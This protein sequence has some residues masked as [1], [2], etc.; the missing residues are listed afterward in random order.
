M[1]GVQRYTQG[2]QDPWS[3]CLN[4]FAEKKYGEMVLKFCED[5]SSGQ[6]GSKTEA[7]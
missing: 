1:V 6:L 7:Q 4:S 2:N 5:G 3:L